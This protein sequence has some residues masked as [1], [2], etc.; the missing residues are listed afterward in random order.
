MHVS[1][2]KSEISGKVQ[3]S[4]I[5]LLPAGRQGL[6][7]NYTDYL[8]YRFR[9]KVRGADATEDGLLLIPKKLISKDQAWFWTKE[10]QE[11]EKEADEAIARGDLSK[12]FKKAD[13]LIGHLRKR[14]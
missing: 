4:L 9:L 11:K 10:W 2:E 1:T 5:T 6:W 3:K 7:N 14:R 8:E 13:E 12:P